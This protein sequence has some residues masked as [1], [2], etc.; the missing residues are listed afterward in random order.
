MTNV[1]VSQAPIGSISLRP[2]DPASRLWAAAYSAAGARQENR[3]R[4]MRRL[5]FLG[6]ASTLLIAFCGVGPAHADNGPHISGVGQ[7]AGAHGCDGCHRANTLKAALGVTTSSDGLCLTCH[8]PSASGASTNV[9]DGIGYAVDGSQTGSKE[10]AH[11]ALRGGGFSHAL[12]GSAKA[13][14]DTYLCG[15]SLRAKNQNIPVLAAGQVT[16]SS[17]RVAGITALGGIASTAADDTAV[18][19]QCTSCHDPH[20]NG[21]YRILRSLPAG[22]GTST[23]AAP[24]RIPDARVKI[25]TT[26][27]YWLTGDSG[28][29]TY[30]NGVLGGTGVPD[31][32]IGNIAQW[33]TTCHTARHSNPNSKMGTGENCITCH[34]A[35]GSNASMSGAG[36][37][38]S[39]SGA[40]I[41]QVKTSDDLAAPCVSSRLLR[42]DNAAACLMC[43]NG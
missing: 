2:P 5:P 24:V 37:R 12:I 25:Y 28:V 29:P 21:N 40:E 22:T 7:I 26:T 43:H 9:I 32:F 10:T 14:K 27:N 33:C 16:T 36:A 39:M 23:P 31:G 34:V 42:V 20:G 13:T 15:T 11:A 18:V 3:G 38:T 41:V 35:H 8:G 1:I 4:A 30:V 6:A 19:L 17:H